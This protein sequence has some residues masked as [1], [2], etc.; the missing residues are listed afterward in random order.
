MFGRTIKVLKSWYNLKILK[1]W[2]K[3]AQTKMEE[4]FKY[5]QTY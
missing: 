4:I 5:I 3:N 2:G 1:H